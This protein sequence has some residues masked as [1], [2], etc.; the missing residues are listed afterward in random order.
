LA[1]FFIYLDFVAPNQTA[2]RTEEAGDTRFRS[3]YLMIAERADLEVA[4]ETLV[5]L[6][7]RAQA[8]NDFTLYSEYYR[9]L[10]ARPDVFEVVI[11]AEAA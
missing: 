7:D 9:R 8:T 5:L 2:R 11:V 10:R 6:H 3:V 1:S 4:Q